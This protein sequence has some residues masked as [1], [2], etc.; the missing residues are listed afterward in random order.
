MIV[1]GIDPGSIN[2]GW[3]AINYENN[4][5]QLLEYGVISLKKIETDFPKRIDLLFKKLSSKIA[6][7]K[8]DV[9][10]IESVFNAKNTQSLIKLTHARAAA[11]LAGTTN[12]AEIAE[13]SPNEV[14]KSVT[15][16]G[17]ASKEQVQFMVKT[18]LKIEE[19]PEL[20]DATDALAVALSYCIRSGRTKSKSKNWA[21]FIKNNPDRII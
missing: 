16:R 9:V 3:G 8:T 19:T 5:F 18:L 4:K 21:E 1:F 15:G 13:L 10:C 11:L 6:E 7:Y 17:H 2:C 12:N 14:K 20:F